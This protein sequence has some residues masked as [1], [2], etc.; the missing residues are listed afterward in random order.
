M[1]QITHSFADLINLS[2]SFPIGIELSVAHDGFEGKVIGYYITWE[3][4]PGVVLQ[5]QN[6]RVVHVYSTKWFEAPKDE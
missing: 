2:K 3:N 4:K 1:T 6:T 5:Q